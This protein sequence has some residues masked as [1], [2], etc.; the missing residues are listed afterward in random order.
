MTNHS[1]SGSCAITMQEVQN[2]CLG[3]NAILSILQGKG[4]P[5][6]G[7]TCLKIDPDYVIKWHEDERKLCINVQWEKANEL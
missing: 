3:E 5:V 2:S 4:G 6:L 7:Y 1:V